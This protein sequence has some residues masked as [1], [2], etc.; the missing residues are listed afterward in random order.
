MAIKY[1]WYMAF[2]W[3][4]RVTANKKLLRMAFVFLKFPW[5]LKGFKF[6]KLFKSILIQ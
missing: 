3:V 5:L 1:F 6:F 2:K 4:G